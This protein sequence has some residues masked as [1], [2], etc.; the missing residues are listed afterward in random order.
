MSAAYVRDSGRER[1]RAGR[2]SAAAARNS[3]AIWIAASVAVL[4]FTAA[5]IGLNP[6][7]LA[8][9]MPYMLDFF[10]RMF[11]PDLEHLA[12][13]GARPSRRSRSRSGER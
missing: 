3:C 2:A 13:L 5:Q 7:A 10:S 4:G 12:L 1:A 9:G 6:I 11:P 8:K